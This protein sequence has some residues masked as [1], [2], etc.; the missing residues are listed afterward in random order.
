MRRFLSAALVLSTFGCANDETPSAAADEYGGTL[1][2][3]TGA[4]INGLMPPLIYTVQEN[5]VVDIIFERLAEPGM[6]LNSVGD[7]GFTPE[8]AQSWEWSEDSLSIAFSLLP[9]AHFHDGQPVTAQDIVFTHEVYTDPRTG[10]GEAELLMQIDS[11]TAR[12][13]ATAVFW[14]AR[15]YPQQFFDATYHMRILPKHLLSNV[16]RGELRTTDF[17]RQPVGSGQFRFVRHQPGAMFEVAADTT[18][19]RGRPYID[20]IVWTV[21]SDLSAAMTRLLARDADFLEMV[22]AGKFTDLAAQPELTATRY[23]SL[24]VGYLQFNLQDPR[25]PGVP[26]PIFGNREVRR[27][28]AMSLDRPRLVSAVF[29]S[30]AIVAQGPFATVLATA[31]SPVKQIEF[32]T[33]RAQQIL[34]SLGWRDRDGDGV[35]ERNGRPLRFT[36]VSPTSSLYRMRMAILIEDMLSDVGVK[37]DLQTMDINPFMQYSNSRAFDAIFS[38]SY[39]D[40]SPAGIR[41]SWTSEGARKG[42]SNLSGYENPVFDRLVDSAA[43]SMD[44]SYRGYY[45]RAYETIIA[46]APAVWLYETVNFAAHDKRVQ[47]PELRADAWWANIGK[48]KIAPD[49]RLP[50]DGIEKGIAAN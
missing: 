16:A 38:S 13:S 28:I 12:D 26:H 20:N 49:G 48:W 3:S 50:R 30:L 39:Y 7:A 9:N 46:D 40:P 29:D 43:S 4:D 21:T 18:H 44:G 8:L 33:A 22:P 17:A 24:G 25:S 5:S 47:L 36:L 31:D 32:D 11:V 35:R 6:D 34:D 10:S 27:A 41:Q 2:I 37:V 23:A 15:R 45:R 1:I 14:F 42:G 19:A